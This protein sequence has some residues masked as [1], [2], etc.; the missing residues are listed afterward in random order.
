MN[1]QPSEQAI[2]RNKQ[3]YERASEQTN[4]T[5]H[6]INRVKRNT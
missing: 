6:T 3:S 5:L 4:I 2:E 1:E